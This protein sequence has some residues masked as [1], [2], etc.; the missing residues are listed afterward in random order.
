[1]AVI[2]VV[3]P[4]SIT[5]TAI[6]LLV[7]TNV[8]PAGSTFL[9]GICGAILGDEV[10]Y[11]IG[12]YYKVHLHKI[13]PF[14]KHPEFLE[15][16]EVFFSKHGGKSVFIGRFFGPMRSMIPMVAGM[17]K[18]NQS[19]FLIAA[20]PSASIWAV[21]YIMP[22]VLLGALSMELPP[23]IATQF[24]LVAL[25]AIAIFWGLVWLA[26]RFAKT[27]YQK[28]DKYIM[29][30]WLSLRNCGGCKWFVKLLTDPREPDNHQQLT[31]FILAIITLILFLFALQ[32]MIHHGFITILN[33]PL[34]N[35]LRSFRTARLDKVMIAITALGEAKLLLIFGSLFFLWLLYKRYF[36]TAT[37]WALLMFAGA[38]IVDGLKHLVFV[39]RPNGILNFQ[40]T[41]SFPS[42]H[43]ALSIAFFGFLAALIS[44][45]LEESK[46]WI[47]YS[48]TS[49]VIIL[50][51]LSRLYLGA[52]W[53]S[54]IICSIFIG[55][56][57]AIFFT[58]SYRRHHKQNLAIGQLI[59]AYLLLFISTWFGYNA[60]Y[61]QKHVIGYSLNWPTKIVTIKE[62]QNQTAEIPIYRENRLG[63]PIEVF[64]IESVNSISEIQ[65]NLLKQGWIPQPT[66]LTLNVVLQRL[67]G[68]SVI[69]HMPL[70]PQLYHNKPALLI[71][72]KITSN[73][74]GFYALQL[75]DAD[76]SVI[77][78]KM[79]LNIND[80]TISQSENLKLYLGDISFHK[81]EPRELKP[82]DLLHHNHNTILELYNTT[83]GLNSLTKNYQL[84]KLN[85]PLTEL[86]IEI[87]D[88]N[89]DG[90]IILI[91]PKNK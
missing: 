91:L 7:G 18:M 16:S 30:W 8:I 28:F 5:M 79:H 56:F 22:G 36:Y 85:Y 65:N 11:L 15:K 59:T 75:W 53:L 73:N 64:N 45:Y 6:G 41:S 66:D 34:F 80:Q 69:S 55:L 31:L 68:N 89:W 43:T 42:G 50:I 90:K 21:M 13:W 74:E 4:G 61:F 26:H 54:D 37:H 49:I 86:P 44:R 32:N 71:L 33:E 12:R 70:L 2:G 57:L 81:L 35:L 83:E 10:S 76:I 39:P 87:R 88:L 47:P 14:K 17:L 58:I 52:H 1:M 19:R 24:A 46:R 60:V 25:L 77:N 63:R 38:S 62:L 51:I 72:T 9:W 40:H 20:I 29:E 27:V 84:Q 3:I 67:L 82:K 48:L 78:N 23:K